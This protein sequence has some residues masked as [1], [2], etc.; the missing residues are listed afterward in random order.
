[1]LRGNS[2]ADEE[3]SASRRAS[4]TSN[5]RV[6]TVDDEVWNPETPTVFPEGEQGV[7]QIFRSIVAHYGQRVEEASN[8]L[9][10]KL[11]RKGAASRAAFAQMP[12]LGQ[13][14]DTVGELAWVPHTHHAHSQRPDHLNTFGQAWLCMNVMGSCRGQLAE[15]LPADGLGKLIVVT[16]GSWSI[17]LWPASSVTDRGAELVDAHDFL[18]DLGQPEFATWASEHLKFAQVGTGAGMWIPY[19]WQTLFVASVDL[20]EFPDQAL[21][22]DVAAA[23]L[24]Q[25]YLSPSMATA[26]ADALASVKTLHNFLDWASEQVKEKTEWAS[27]NKFWELQGPAFKEWLA[28]LV[29][30]GK[31]PMA[32]IGDT[33][34]D[35]TSQ[36]VDLLALGITTPPASQE[37]LASASNNAE[38]EGETKP[39]GQ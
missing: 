37:G 36:Q 17:C 22:V 15:S 8:K 30:H 12:A 10:Q 27:E 25:P 13:P 5:C 28:S 24:V 19:G 29:S 20:D 35:S 32:A 9:Q 33:E 7:G 38:P 34:L 39:S 3:P 1:M 26:T 16:G 11:E 23:M 21:H 31:V 2:A 4:P 18:E 14:R 6:Q